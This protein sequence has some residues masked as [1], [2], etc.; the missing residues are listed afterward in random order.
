MNQDEV[1]S[2]L[3]VL[4]DDRAVK[5]WAKM[6]HPTENYYGVGLTKLKGLAKEV[7]KNHELALSLWNSGIHDAMLLS[8]MIEE[9]KKVS[10]E[11]IQE[12]TQTGFAFHDLSDK[13]CENVIAKTP[14]LQEMIEKWYKSD[15]ENLERSAYILLNAL[16]KK[17]NKVTDGYFETYLNIIES[18][19]QMEKNWVKEGMIYALMGI[20]GRNQMLNVKAVS[21]AKNIGE[22]TVDYGDTS[23][24]TPDPLKHLTSDRVMKKLA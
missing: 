11:Q 12:Q 17:K 9:P 10:R 7:K 14:Y 24:Q 23:C 18:D 3:K 8:T 19:I 13:Y 1:L 2:R 4:S 20:G 21:T 6:G 5:I 22:I 15:N 16:A